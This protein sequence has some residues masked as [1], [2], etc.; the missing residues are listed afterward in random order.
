MSSEAVLGGLQR[1]GGLRGPTPEAVLCELLPGHL[2]HPWPPDPR[3]TCCQ[4]LPQNWHSPHLLPP[5]LTF[6]PGPYKL[7]SLKGNEILLCKTK[8]EEY[9]L[10][11]NK[12]QL[13]KGE[14]EL[15]MR[16]EYCFQTE[17]SV[18]KTKVPRDRHCIAHQGRCP[19]TR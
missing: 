12:F 17:Y 11:I 9:A 3:S 14:R 8:V 18:P 4:P 6:M 1:E 5:A 19:A 15:K 16:S 2:I 10:A 13:L 7:R